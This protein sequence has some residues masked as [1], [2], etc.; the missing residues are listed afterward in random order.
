MYLSWREGAPPKSETDWALFLSAPADSHWSGRHER[1]P[2]PGAGDHR[3]PSFRRR[4]LE[5]LG[6]LEVPPQLS[7]LAAGMPCEPYRIRRPAPAT[8]ATLCSKS[9]VRSNCW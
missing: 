8:C 3:R 9:N 2:Y 7:R 4:T 1:W 6:L 5:E